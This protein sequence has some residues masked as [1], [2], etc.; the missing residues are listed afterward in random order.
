MEKIYLNA[1]AHSPK[2]GEPTL[3]YFIESR[4]NAESCPARN[5]EVAR[6]L[7]EHISP[8]NLEQVGVTIHGDWAT[9]PDHRL[10]FLIETESDYAAE[11][12]AAPFA[13]LGV[14]DVKPGPSAREVCLGE[15]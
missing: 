3:R 11:F 8:T 14:V 9:E 10:M 7:R 6:A 15:K 13:L 2:I 5:L 4:H 12:F 1:S